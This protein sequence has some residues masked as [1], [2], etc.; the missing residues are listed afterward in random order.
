MDSGDEVVV[1]GGTYRETLSW[2]TGGTGKNPSTLRAAAYRLG[3]FDGD[4]KTDIPKMAADLE[5]AKP[6][7]NDPIVLLTLPRREG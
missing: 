6:S 3:D 1:R 2:S 5:T 7:A 4:G